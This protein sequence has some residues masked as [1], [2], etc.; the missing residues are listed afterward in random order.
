M[1]NSVLFPLKIIHKKDYN[2]SHTFFDYLFSKKNLLFQIF[3]TNTVETYSEGISRRKFKNI[4]RERFVRTTETQKRPSV[5]FGYDNGRKCVP[6][7]KQKYREK[8]TLI[9]KADLIGLFNN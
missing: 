7:T 8:C 3:L 4:Q 9:I 2:A 6:Q 5:I 1:S